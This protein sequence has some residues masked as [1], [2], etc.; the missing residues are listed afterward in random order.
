MIMGF[1]F[2]NFVNPLIL[3]ALITLPLL[4]WLLRLTPPKAKRIVFGGAYFLA[5]I[6]SSEKTSKSIPLWLLILRMMIITLIILSFA[7]PYFKNSDPLIQKDN[8]NEIA[9]IIDNS[10]ASASNWNIIKNQARS[11]IKDASREN[12]KII[13]ATPHNYTEDNLS[14]LLEDTALST[15]EQFEP[16]LISIK[17]AN[18]DTLLDDLSR[19]TENKALVSFYLNDGLSNKRENAFLETLSTNSLSLTIFDHNN[20]KD[21]ASLHRASSQTSNEITLTTNSDI[22]DFTLSY[23]DDQQQLLYTQKIQIKG[24]QALNRITLDAD[25]SLLRSTK[26]ISLTEQNHAGAKF[27]MRSNQIEKS[28]GLL[29]KK[30]KEKTDKLNYL[31]PYFYIE[32][33]LSPYHKVTK[34]NLGALSEKSQILVL[35]D[36]TDINEED[37]SDIYKWIENGGIFIRFADENLASGLHS[38]LSPVTLRITGREFDTAF[39][40]Q[41]PQKIKLYKENSPFAPYNIP[42]DILVNKQILAEPALDLNQ[43]TLASLEDGTPIITAEQRG[44]GWLVLFHVDAT[45]KWSTLPLSGHFIDQLNA[46]TQLSLKDSNVSD[47]DADNTSYRLIQK[48]D[49][50]GMLRPAGDALVSITLP[51][52][53]NQ[54]TSLDEPAGLYENDQG[55][56]FNLNFGQTASRDIRNSLN[57]EPS[58]NIREYNKTKDFEFKYLL[59]LLALF[60]FLLD[61][62]YILNLKGV[63]KM[64]NILPTLLLGY[65]FIAFSPTTSFAQEITPP[66]TNGIYLAYVQSGDPNI[67]SIAENGLNNLMKETV[68]R[69]SADIKGVVGVNIERDPLYPYPFIYWPLKNSGQALFFLSQKASDK[70]SAYFAS[71]GLLLIDTRDQYLFSS[72][73]DDLQAL[74]YQNNASNRLQ[75]LFNYIDVPPME[76][77][78][79]N[80][81]LGR[82]FYLL[83]SFPGLYK[84]GGLWIARQNKSVNDGVTPLVIGS[85]DWMSAWARHDNGSPVLEIPYGGER[86]RE[87]S[88][89]FGVNLILYALTGN[90]KEDQIHIPF[91]LERLDN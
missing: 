3:G 29:Q 57:L 24:E 61:W 8:Q 81:V 72:N 52:K 37:L 13:L 40:W 38:D 75:T 68:L 87:L 22:K 46:L 67:D 54:I 70:L 73:A 45:P 16:T 10:W 15:L 71:G 53:Q 58:L 44:L 19:L 55:N 1:E 14:L 5:Q 74:N 30:A 48:L 65:V 32:K 42:S 60:L 12:K 56:L 47:T 80:H 21:L 11:L 39:S 82:T 90:Y 88:Y 62:L 18:Y 43:R 7:D 89:R 6:K 23:M 34:G 28:I 33:A 77:L 91:I 25:S 78:P 17:Q 41:D 26:L 36:S 51:L 83:S 9:I 64:Q 35:S 31:N 86:Q 50:N 63:L 2:L 66:N 85:N 69:T 76:K 4:W 79:K 49:F 20:V 84:N 59:L 27:W